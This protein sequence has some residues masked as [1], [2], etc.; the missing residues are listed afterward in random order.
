MA[1]PL[2]DLSPTDHHEYDER[3]VKQ[4]HHSHAGKTTAT[5]CRS[6]TVVVTHSLCEERKRIEQ[7]RKKKN[8]A[9]SYTRNPHDAKV[10]VRICCVVV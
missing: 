4:P 2:K 9:G 3:E 6:V 5:D 8:V 10:F 1:C 7:L